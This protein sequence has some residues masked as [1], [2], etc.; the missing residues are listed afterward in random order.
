LAG[1]IFLID[2]G[3]RGLPEHPAALRTS[4]QFQARL[5]GGKTE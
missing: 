3:A 1:S 5:Q 4:T 2:A